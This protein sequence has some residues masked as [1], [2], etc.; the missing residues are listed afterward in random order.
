M[1]RFNPQ[2]HSV[3]GDVL[4]YSAACRSLTGS[5]PLRRLLGN[6]LQAQP[7]HVAI[8]SFHAALATIYTL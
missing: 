7:L 6:L 3:Y 5:A 4:A 8:R 1:Q 2:L